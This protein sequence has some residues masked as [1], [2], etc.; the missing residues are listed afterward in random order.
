MIEV[1][2]VA[3]CLAYPYPAGKTMNEKLAKYHQIEKMEKE[4]DRRYPECRGD[5]STDECYARCERD[6]PIT[7]EMIK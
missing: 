5:T 7:V 3:G 2:L 6:G 4:L 1:M